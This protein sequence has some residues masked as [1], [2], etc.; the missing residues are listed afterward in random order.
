MQAIIRVIILYKNVCFVYIFNTLLVKI[1][2]MKSKNRYLK[3]RKIILYIR[4]DLLFL[5]M[6]YKAQEYVG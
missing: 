2:K 3:F 1:L 6:L 4:I 5:I